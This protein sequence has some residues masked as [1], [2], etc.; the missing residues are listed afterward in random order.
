[1]I[2]PVIT[3]CSQLHASMTRTQTNR[4]DSI[5]SRATKLIDNPALT[6]TN[7]KKLINVKS[8]LFVRKCLEKL[9]CNVFDDYFEINSHSQNTRGNN[10]LLKL[11][12]IKI[13]FERKGFY[14]SGAILY[15][16]L[17]RELQNQNDFK[18]FKK[19]LVK[20]F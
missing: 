2:I 8:C 5:S 1:M 13:E 3:Y 14:F 15:N 11:P 18:S 10:T 19:L 4:L 7:I 6:L 9:L 12:R 16:K 20:D 17:P